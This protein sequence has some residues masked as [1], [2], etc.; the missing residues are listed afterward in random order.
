MIWYITENDII[1]TDLEEEEEEPEIEDE[2]DYSIQSTSRRKISATE[3][4]DEAEEW[5]DIKCPVCS[6]MNK[7]PIKA[8]K[9]KEQNKPAVMNRS[10]SMTTLP[11]SVSIEKLN[12]KKLTTYNSLFNLYN[13]AK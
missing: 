11:K 12:T 10:R 7:I 4:K 3:K 6:K 9:S 1:V 13:T 2:I 8:L 5:I